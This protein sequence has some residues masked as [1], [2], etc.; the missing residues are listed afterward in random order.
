MTIRFM[1]DPVSQPKKETMRYLILA[2]TIAA[3]SVPASALVLA[4]PII[5]MPAPPAPPSKCAP[6]GAPKTPDCYTA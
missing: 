2:L 4:G 1:L 5:K 3:F 6:Y